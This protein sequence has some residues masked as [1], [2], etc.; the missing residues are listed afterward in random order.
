M[1]E[2]ETST[3]DTAGLRF[4]HV[5]DQKRGNRRIRRRSSASHD[6]GSCLRRQGM[7]RDDHM[8]VRRHKRLCGETWGVLRFRLRLGQGRRHKK[9][10]CKEEKIMHMA[11]TPLK[12]RSRFELAL[13]LR[14]LRLRFA[15]L[16]TNGCLSGHPERKAP[17]A[18]SRRVLRTGVA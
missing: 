14:F 5:E 18:W 8:F 1:D 9:E 17:R 10:S 2:R 4:D 7:C 13:R 12:S 15:T 6:L 11:R 16:R 3:A